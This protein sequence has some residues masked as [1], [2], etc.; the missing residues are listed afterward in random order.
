MK[1]RIKWVEGRTFVGE[2]GSGHK[3]VLGTATGPDG[4]TPGPSPMEM[5]LIGT[6]GCSAFDVVH[7]LE[8][9]REAIEDC[10][11]EL[12]ADR[13]EQDPRVFTR[14]HMHFIV[15][16]RGLAAK[17]VERAVALSIEKYCSASAMLAKTATITHDFEVVDTSIMAG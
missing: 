4:P 9:G 13:A 6:G 5:V 15:K 2:S 16:G 3:V 7:I 12:D 8:K 10:V 17:K 14:I 11:V 1:A